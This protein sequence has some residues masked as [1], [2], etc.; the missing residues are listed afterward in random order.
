MANLRSK[1]SV[2]IVH[3][4]KLWFLSVVGSVWICFEYAGLIAMLTLNIFYLLAKKLF[5]LFWMLRKLIICSLVRNRITL[6]S[7]Y[8]MYVTEV[9]WINLMTSHEYWGR[10]NQFSRSLQDCC[11]NYIPYKP[12]FV[13][14]VQFEDLFLSTASKDTT[15][16]P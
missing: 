3:K 5:C 16:V 7:L 1:G 11:P 9:F 15:T 8:P 14:R 6:S 2:F 12:A 13:T 4:T 10:H